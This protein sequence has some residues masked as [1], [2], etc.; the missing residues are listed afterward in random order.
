MGGHGKVG[1]WRAL[2]D[3]GRN[4]RTWEDIEGHEDMGGHGRTW[5]DI[6]GHGRT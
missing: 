5:E 4:E 6:G 2:E 3:V 1:H